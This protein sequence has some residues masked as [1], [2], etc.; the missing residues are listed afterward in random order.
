M[1]FLAFVHVRFKISLTCKKEQ[2]DNTQIIFS[3]NFIMEL[4]IKQS[5]KIGVFCSVHLHKYLNRLADFMTGLSALTFV[6]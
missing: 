4:A 2:W 1:L 3:M 5:S 6:G